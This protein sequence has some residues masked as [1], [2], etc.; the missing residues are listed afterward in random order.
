MYVAALSV[1]TVIAVAY[2]AIFW[3]IARKV[4]LVDDQWRRNPL[5]LATAGIFFSCGIGHGLHTVHLLEHGPTAALLFDPHVVAWDLTT[6]VVAT[7]YW[8][9]RHGLSALGGSGQLFEDARTLE[10]TQLA[11]VLRELFDGVHVLSRGAHRSELPAALRSL[12]PDRVEDLVADVDGDGRPRSL[13][14]RTADGAVL[15][16]RA[17]LWTDQVVLAWRDVT[18]LREAQRAHADVQAQL[19]AAFDAA[20]VAMLVLKDGIVDRGNRALQALT[21]GRPTTGR[22]LD[23]LFAADVGPGAGERLASLGAGERTTGWEARLLQADGRS[24]WVE[25]TLADVVGDGGAAPG[26]VVVHL[27]DVE[28]RKAYEDRLRHL[29]DHDPLTGL[30]NRRR[31]DEELR[32]HCD[33]ASPGQ[34]RGAL[35]LLDLDNFKDVNDTLGHAAGDRLLEGV[36]Q[37]L[38]REVRDGDVVARL[39]GDEFA[40]LSPTADRAQ[41]IALGNRLCRAVREHA[42]VV[43]GSTEATGRVTC[44]LGL[45][46]FAGGSTPESALVAADLTLYDA[47]ESG[48]DRVAVYSDDV[49]HQPLTKSRMQMLDRLRRALAA[50]TLAVVAQPIVDL[51]TRSVVHVELLLRLPDDEGALLPPSAFLHLAEQSDLVFEVDTWMTQFAVGYAARHPGSSVCVNVSGRSLSDPATVGRLVQVV[52][53]AGLPPGVLVVE[54]TETA[55]MAQLHTA[56]SGLTRLREAGCAVAL[57]D[58]GAGFAGLSYVKHLPFDLLKIDGQF[59]SGC[60]DDPADLVVIDAVVRLARGL[61]KAVIAEHVESEAIARLLQAHGVGLGQGFHL[62][63]PRLV[64]GLPRPRTAP[65]AGRLPV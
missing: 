10:R 65:E 40:V 43:G 47:K 39:G 7:W 15:E 23:E 19:A 63:E 41:A 57:D 17:S 9:L 35:L 59:V 37:V 64:S 58:F 11:E 12:P 29:A 21:G 26:Q 31:L 34:D 36:A 33:G 53:D 30:V 6:A 2:L 24:R 56:R 61:G 51:A 42:R 13:E 60:V 52:V 55:P 20:P 45:T 49:E 14:A 4:L 1:A 48:R 38:R 18:A 44:S 8:S 5:A 50:G 62:G 46:L 28:D 16:V 32:R 3:T 25:A 22:S 27:V 54:V